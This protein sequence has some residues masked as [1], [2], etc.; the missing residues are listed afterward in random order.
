MNEQDGGS[1]WE[2]IYKNGDVESLPW[3]Y[4]G[5]DPDFNGALESLDISRGDMLDLC[6]GPGT[7]AIAMAKLGYSV[8]AIDIAGAAV[9]KARIRASRQGLEISFRQGD[10][11]GNDLDRS[12]DIIFDR[13]CYHV[14]PDERRAE[15]AGVV[16]KL[17]RRGGYL[18]LKCFSYREKRSE[19]PYRIS[20]DEIQVN[21]EEL[22]EIVSIVGTVFQ[23]VNREP[24]PQA[25]FC[26]M[27]RR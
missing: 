15:Y 26:T 20:P 13:G 1:R 17:L 21:F 11:F 4:P 16:A 14:F 23:G 24:E 10:I 22:Y 2:D 9:E 5:L 18:L 19:G 25:L 8:T 27:R 12:F 3:F 7:Q 6:T